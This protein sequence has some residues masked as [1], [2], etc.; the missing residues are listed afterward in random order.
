M[1]TPLVTIA[2]PI[3]NAEAYLEYAILSCI[4][5]TYKNW[6]LLLMCD[7]STD[8]SDSIAMEFAERDERIRIVK[9]NNNRGLVYRLNQSINMANG[10]YYARMD[11]DDIM[12]ID[13]LEKEVSF[14][15]KNPVIDVVG[16]SMMI[17]DGNNNIIG[18]ALHTSADTFVHPSVLGK[19]QWFKNNSYDEKAV[20]AEDFDLWSRTRKI[21]HFSNI[22]SP[23]LFYR[24]F[25]MPTTSKVLA[26]YR[27]MRKLSSRYTDYGK[28][29]FWAI[30]HYIIYTIKIFVFSTVS[31]IGMQKLIIKHRHQKKIPNE[32]C[33]TLEDLNESIRHKVSNLI[34][35]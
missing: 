35:Y 4:N 2:I 20:R 7:G 24:T 32:L 12:A 17:I 11:A 15:E 23:L 33:L 25:G 29:K 30:K 19:T 9:D 34:R 5:Q 21:S 16:S 18:S 10:K 3:Y 27:T 31:L 13:R 6:E 26:T 1:K 22:E 8:N 28:N 14:L